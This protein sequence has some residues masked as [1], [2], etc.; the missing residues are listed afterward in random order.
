MSKQTVPEI[1]IRKLNDAPV[2]PDGDYVL[3]WMT[4]NR[5]T[6]WNFSL[7][8]A[9]EHAQALCKPLL[10]FEALRIN[11]RWASDR[12]HRFVLQGMADQRAALASKP[13][14]YYCYVEPKQHA[15]KGLLEALAKQACVVV[16]DDFPCFFLP[17]MLK[18]AARLSPVALEGVDSNGLL[19]MRAADHDYPTAYAFRRFLQKE[20]PKH[21]PHLPVADPLSR[22]DLPKLKSLP[23]GLEKKWP[24][25]SDR[26]L[27]GEISELKKFDIDHTVGPAAFDGGAVAGKKTLD[28]FLKQRLDR[29]GEGRNDP[30]NEAAS[31]LSPYLHF[32]HIS[33]HEVFSRVTDREKWSL[34]QLASSTSGSRSGWWGMTPSAE[35]FLDELIT[36]RELGYNM[37]SHRRDY[38]RYE[39]LPEWAQK[40]LAEHADDARE[41]EYTLEQLENAET[42]DDIW[43]AAQRQLVRDGRMHNYLRMLWGKKILQWTESPQKALEFMIELNNKYAVDGRNPNSYSGIF[44]VLGRYDRAWGPERPVFGKIRYMT[45]D[46]TRRKLDLDNYLATYGEE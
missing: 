21:L 13:V 40:T 43:N 15:A 24:E 2:Q 36:W 34:D 30:D 37:C 17:A 23:A 19:P 28:R 38:D 41:A 29:Y 27:S 26:L 35:S 42:Y 39:S 10:I 20:L 12:L 5:R 32:G 6:Q 7:Q 18:L 33:A 46:S 44:W 25:A 14:R 22:V 8:R 4:A 3:Y 31:G 45:S 11:Y 1:R 16:T 9:V